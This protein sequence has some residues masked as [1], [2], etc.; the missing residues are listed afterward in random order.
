MGQHGTNDQ[1]NVLHW[2]EEIQLPRPKK[3]I[4]LQT[5]AKLQPFLPEK[6][7]L[8]KKKSSAI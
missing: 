6:I 5:I 8:P 3:D 4:Y 7:L 1:P 2:R